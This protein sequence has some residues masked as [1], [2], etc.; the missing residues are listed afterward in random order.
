MLF[1]NKKII[2][3]IENRRSAQAVIKDIE[4]AFSFT[5]FGPN[6][7]MAVVL[8]AFLLYKAQEYRYPAY[9]HYEDIANNGLE[10]DEDVLLAIKDTFN[11]KMWE[12]IKPL[13]KKYS[14]VD[15][16]TAAYIYDLS[17]DNHFMSTSDSVVKLALQIL[18]IQK[19][20]SVADL[21]CGVGTFINRANLECPWGTFRGY[22]INAYERAIAKIRSEL[23]SDTTSILLKDVFTITD[24]KDFPKYNKIFSNYPFGMRLKNLGNGAKL[25]DALVTENPELSKATSSDWIFNALL[26][27]LLT[28]NGKAVGIMTNGSTWNT[29]DEPMRKYFVEN[30]MIEAVLSLPPRMFSYTMI[31]TTMIIISKNNKSV[32]LVDATNICQQGRR[33][34]EFSYE[35]I[36]QIIHALNQDTEFSKEISLEQLRENEYTLSLGRYLEN[37]FVINSPVVFE[38]VIKGI[39]RGAP[40][41]AKQL[42][43]MISETRTNMQYLMLANIK[44]GIIDEKLPYLS[45]IDPKYE[46]YCLKDNDLIIS[47]NGYPYKIAVASIKKNQR[48]LANGNLYIIELDQEKIDP[49]YL[50]AFFES[51][52]GIAILKSITVGATIPNIGIDKL[53]KIIIPLPPLEKQKKVVDRYKATLDEIAVLNLKLKI[54]KSRLH[55]I[56]DE[57]SGE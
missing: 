52:Q 25:L 17:D 2:Q 51:V 11:E 1:L 22:E 36:G 16:A 3:N 32:R 8:G 28:E 42:D 31:P 26:Y 39:S 48:I 53:K 41:T 47:K 10:L 19:T 23:I 38:S 13:V 55:H 30:G 50:K 15:L 5:G 27:S 9:L 6:R 29:I 12:I 43:E 35:N 18:N 49:Y 37:D 4:S 46:K 57:E 20:D 44:D 56:F 14:Q 7:G 40:C 24:S 34:N 45:H 33:Y 54:V 21:C